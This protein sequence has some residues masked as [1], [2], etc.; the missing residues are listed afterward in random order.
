MGQRH[1]DFEGNKFFLCGQSTYLRRGQIKETLGSVNIPL[2][3]ADELINPGDVV[4]ADDDG[5][6]V[7]RRE[8]AESVLASARPRGKRGR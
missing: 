6:C 1:Q 8:E 5:V 4:I 7:V 3:C 2:V